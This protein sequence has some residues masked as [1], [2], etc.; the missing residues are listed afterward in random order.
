VLKHHVP[1]TRELHASRFA[2]EQLDFE[3]LFQVLDSQT[4]RRGRKKARGSAPRHISRVGHG[5]EQADVGEVVAHGFEFINSK[6]PEISLVRG[7]RNWDTARTVATPS[8]TQLMM[9]Q[10]VAVSALGVPAAIGPY[11]HAVCVGSLLFASGQ[12]PLD[13]AGQ[14]MPEAIADQAK[15]VLDNLDKVAQAGGS[16]LSQ[17]VKLT[18]YLTNLSEFAQVNEIMSAALSQPFPARATIGVA[19]LPRGARVEI[20]GVFFSG[21]NQ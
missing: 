4:G 18:V 8:L 20:E 3:C 14:S 21:V 15:L 11:S 2:F 19:A 10:P 7:P 5:N 13:P 6:V 17:A 16:S 12:L 1:G 9:S